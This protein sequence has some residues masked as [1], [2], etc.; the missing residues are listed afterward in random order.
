MS[1]CAI[2][3]CKGQSQNNA[4]VLLLSDQNASKMLI[5]FFLNKQNQADDKNTLS[6]FNFNAWGYVNVPATALATK[7]IFS[8]C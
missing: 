7:N 6:H 4:I 5:C 1:L 2:P 8:K 3:F